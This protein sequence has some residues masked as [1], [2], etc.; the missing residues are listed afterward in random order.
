MFKS[1]MEKEDNLIILHGAMIIPLVFLAWCFSTISYKN[2]IYMFIGAFVFAGAAILYRYVWKLCW[3]NKH[4]SPGE[5]VLIN[6]SV[7]ILFILL[8]LIAH[9]EFDKSF[10]A[11]C[12]LVFFLWILVCTVN[13][14]QI[15]K[16]NYLLLPKIKVWLFEHKFLLMLLLVVLMLSVEGVG[17]PLKWDGLLY[18]DAVKNA[19]IGSVSSLSLYGHVSVTAGFLYRIF[20]SLFGMGS[21]G[22]ILAN[23]LLLLASVIA[24]YGIVKMIIP[25]KKDWQY[26]LA[27]L[28]YGTSPFLSGMAGYFS[29]DWFCVCVV[30]I[31]LYF[32]FKREWVLASIAAVVFCLTKEPALIAYTGLW[33]GVILIDFFTFKDTFLNRIKHI[34]CSVHFYILI[35][36][37]LIWFVIY[38]ILGPWSAGNGGFSFDGLYIIEKLK[39]FLLFDFN[40][41]YTSVIIFSLCLIIK[42]HILLRNSIWLVPLFCSN[43]CLLVFNCLFKTAN[44]PRYIDSFISVSLLLAVLSFWK[45]FENKNCYLYIFSLLSILNVFCCYCSFDPLS[46]SLFEKNNTG[47]GALYT[48]SLSLPMGDGAIY[49]KQMSWVELPISEAIKDSIADD[50]D[51]V[52]SVVDNSV[53][54]YNGMSQYISSDIFS[55]DMYW[56]NEKDRRIAYADEDVYKGEKKKV[57][58]CESIDELEGII[59]N[60]KALSVIYINNINPYNISDKWKLLYSKEYKYRGWTVKRDVITSSEK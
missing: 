18:Y 37:Y 29:T 4:S 30:T 24:F 53:Y 38:V 60:D 32:I 44:H 41:I 34:F 8:N 39:V 36:P 48:T 43:F 5:A 19:S 6:I 10:L 54:A 47:N 22:M 49:N 35:I 20:F 23:V 25:G 33:G 7:S 16:D 42:E 13:F 31:L 14:A 55:D 27:S 58:Y 17:Y 56:N 45:A 51:I 50:N 28:L 52:I 57:Y 2:S 40:W 9:K 21:R 1:I 12:Y 15:K 59:P 26:S 3:E 46:D 11:L